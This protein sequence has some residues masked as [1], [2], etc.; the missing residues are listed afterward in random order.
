MPKAKS[1]DTT[2]YVIRYVQFHPCV[3]PERLPTLRT[4]VRGQ[5]NRKATCDA[6]RAAGGRVTSV[7]TGWFA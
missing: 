6:I 7:R 1:A 5:A 4:V 3:R 2:R